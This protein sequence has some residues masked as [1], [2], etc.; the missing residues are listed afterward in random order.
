M[1]HSTL[2]EDDEK[3]MGVSPTNFRWTT[4][5][6]FGLVSIAETFNLT[7]TRLLDAD[8]YG[9]TSSFLFFAYENER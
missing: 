3:G 6:Y 7:R 5:L 2:Q 1:T 9:W 4:Y 8:H